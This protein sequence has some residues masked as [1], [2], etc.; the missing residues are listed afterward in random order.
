MILNYTQSDHNLSPDR[1]LGKLTFPSLSPTRTRIGP[2]Q[3]LNPAKN[4]V[5]SINSNL[6]PIQIVTQQTRVP[7]PTNIHIYAGVGL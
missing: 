4:R 3:V 2:T 7:C 5:G 1:I 6:G